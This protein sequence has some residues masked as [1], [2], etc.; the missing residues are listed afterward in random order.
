VGI[1]G[2]IFGEEG[3]VL[4]SYKKLIV[5]EGEEVA[6]RVIVVVKNFSETDVGGIPQ[7]VE[8]LTVRR[9]GT[10][11]VET[12]AIFRG[13]HKLLDRAAQRKGGTGETRPQQVNGA[14][15][16]DEGG[17]GV[18]VVINLP[19]IAHRVGKLRVTDSGGGSFAD[20]K[21]E[22]K[23]LGAARLIVH[24]GWAAEEQESGLLDP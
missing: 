14:V 5:G 9:G 12:A 11:Q 16:F 2:S 17:I 21:H 10:H 22:E 8:R 4:I 24:R 20:Q 6:K 7:F 1:V 18:S 19:H 3:N 15:Q 13:T 23:L